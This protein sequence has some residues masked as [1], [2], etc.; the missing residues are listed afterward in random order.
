MSALS[1]LRKDFPRTATYRRSVGGAERLRSLAAR[2][3]R[4]QTLGARRVLG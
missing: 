3:R 2:A 4:R 1:I